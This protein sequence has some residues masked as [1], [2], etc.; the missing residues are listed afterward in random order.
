MGQTG[1]PKTSVRNCNYSLRNNPEELSSQL[2][3]GVSLKSGNDKIVP[4]T[5]LNKYLYSDKGEIKVIV[6]NGIERV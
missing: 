1:C 5:N 4:L 6:N 2:L 3:R